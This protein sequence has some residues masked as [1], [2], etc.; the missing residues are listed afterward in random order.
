MTD[1]KG[2]V[3]KMIAHHRLIETLL[4]AVA[5]PQMAR[6][7]QSIATIRG[8][9]FIGND[10]TTGGSASVFGFP[11]GTSL[12]DQPFTLNYSFDGLKGQQTFP[13]PGK[14]DIA[15]TGDSS[16][17]TA[18]LQ[19]GSDA[20]AFGPSAFGN[21]ETWLSGPPIDSRA[22][23]YVGVQ[24]DANDSDVYA[25]VYPADGEILAS[26][27]SWDA[28]L[29]ASNISGVSGFWISVKTDN[30]Y[31][32]AWGEL[33]VQSITVSGPLACPAGS[34]TPPAAPGGVQHHYV[35]KD[36]DPIC[37]PSASPSC[38]AQLVFAVLQLFPA[39]PRREGDPVNTCDVT[40]TPFGPVVHYVDQSDLSIINVTLPDHWLYP[41]QVVRSVINENGEIYIQ[42]T[43][44]GTGMWSG[45]N[46]MAADTYWRS[47]DALIRAFFQ[48]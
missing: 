47:V 22:Y 20:F 1:S 32:F 26:D 2:T 35:V 17:G 39:D 9:V 28:A 37:S 45:L 11:P 29:S 34:L 5:L 8:T 24:D 40:N 19:I 21:S 42:S 6:T 3:E 16:P 15:G 27:V 38:T 43:G 25:Y 12:A 7:Q 23:Y 36:P 13:V 46:E 18:V 10:G 14:A 48:P 44:T 30:G 41:G 33:N 4:F 31:K